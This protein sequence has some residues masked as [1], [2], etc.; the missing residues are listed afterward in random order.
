[1]MRS[2]QWPVV[3]TPICIGSWCRSETTVQ[4]RDEMSEWLLNSFPIC[5]CCSSLVSLHRIAT[6]SRIGQRQSVSLLIDCF[7]GVFLE[8]HCFNKDQ[9]LSKF[10]WQFDGP[11]LREEDLSFRLKFKWLF[12]T[13]IDR[14]ISWLELREIRSPGRPRGSDPPSIE[15]DLTDDVSTPGG[16]RGAASREVRAWEE[17]TWNLAPLSFEQFFKFGWCSF[18]REDREG[19]SLGSTRSSDAVTKCVSSC[20]LRTLR[21]SQKKHQN[22]TS[23]SPRN[24][25]HCLIHERKWVIVGTLHADRIDFAL[26]ACVLIF[27]QFGFLAVD[28]TFPSFCQRS[29]G[30]YEAGKSFNVTLVK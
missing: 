9:L 21:A 14:L 5:L 1:M 7:R 4:R 27:Q 16:D 20:V 24:K 3:L 2:A 22:S 8:L 29:R 19:R 30:P 28:D 12:S 13:W 6:C 18:K 26:V 23:E 10:L 25:P 11:G 17:T 15:C